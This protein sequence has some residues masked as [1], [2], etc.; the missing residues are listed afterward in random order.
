MQVRGKTQEQFKKH[1]VYQKMGVDQLSQ[2]N[3]EYKC[4]PCDLSFMESKA[5]A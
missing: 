3:Q 5:I 2:R 4:G 1:P